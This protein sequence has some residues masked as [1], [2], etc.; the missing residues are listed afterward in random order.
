MATRSW[1]LDSP[2][3][4]PLRPPS[5][6]TLGRPVSSWRW[7]RQVGPWGWESERVWQ[8][9]SATCSGNGLPPESVSA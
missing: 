1:S 5:D 7:D 2:A 9:E 8:E 4:R 3:M 6:E